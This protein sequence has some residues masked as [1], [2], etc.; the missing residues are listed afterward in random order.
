MNGP[1]RL[2]RM[3]RRSFLGLAAAAVA[4]ACSGSS[5]GALNFYNWSNFIAP[6]TL[7]NF[8]K[9][10]GYRVNYEEFSSADVMYAK[11]KIGV[12]GYDLVVAP[13]Y[14]LRRMIRQDLLLPLSPAPRSEAFLAR[15]KDPPWDPGHRF[16]VPYLW[17]STGVAYNRTRVSGRP[18]SW[19]LLFDPR[20]KRRM[21]VLD[22]KRDTLGMAL[23]KLGYS[24]NSTVTK[25][26]EAA[27]RLLRDNRELW[28]RITSDFI[29]DL[30]REESWVAL[31]WS[32]DVAQARAA[33]AEV[34]YFVP[35]EG[36][37][38][39]VDSL[40][41]P[42]SAP[43]PEAAREFIE[44]MMQPSVAAAVTNATGYGNPIAASLP[45]VQDELRSSPLCFP[46]AE[47][48]DRLV[49]QEDLGSQERLWD[50][51]WEEVK[52]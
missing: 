39:F 43:H 2:A 3:G 9:A 32:G 22:E 45:L 38:F 19:S 23:I 18:D 42:R 46:P 33:N 29:D 40:C 41:I 16:S 11:L 14:M 24:G 28:R 25:E 44:Y 20:Y 10:T 21:T 48:M 15:L 31:G 7:S 1:L 4:S 35:R 50:K 5:R 51:V 37:F 27:G 12:T 13:D 8:E 26:I 49:Y 17:G 6:D 52:V 34:E 36:S 47:V 30:V